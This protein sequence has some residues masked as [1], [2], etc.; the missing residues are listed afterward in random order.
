MASLWDDPKQA[1]KVA[2]EKKVITNFLTQMQHLEELRGDLETACELAVEGEEFLT[3]AEQ[4]LGKFAAG[5]TALEIE[6]LLGG[7][8]DN[9]DAIVTINAG[10]GGTE[11]CDWVA[12]LLRMYLRF[13]EIKGFASEIFDI[14]DGEEAGVKNVT[15]E[16]KGDYAFGLLKAENGVHRLVRNKSFRCWSKETYEFCLGICITCHRC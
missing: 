13:T 4:L 10:A 11:S 7:K 12:M 8:L 14:L 3:E 6:S 1:A 15:F 16:A 2:Q 9:N 5:I